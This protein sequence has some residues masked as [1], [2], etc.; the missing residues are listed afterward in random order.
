MTVALVAMSHSPLLG[1]GSP[2]PADIDRELTETFDTA[3]AFVREFD[4]TLVISFAPDHYNGFFHELMPPFCVGFAAESTGD[5]DSPTGPL[6]VPG[7]L[8]ASLAQSVLDADVDVAI[9]RRMIVD[10]GAVQPLEIL[11]GGIDAIPVIPVFVNGL[12][13]PFAPMRRVRRLGEAIGRF[14]AG[15]DERVL[16]IGSGGLSHDPPVP[17]WATATDVQRRLLLD[18]KNPTPQARAAREQRVKDAAAE[19]VVG[20]STMRDLNPEWDNRFL[21][22]CAAG[23]PQRFD[24]YHHAEMT[25]A[26]GSSAHEVRSWVAAFSAL[27]ASGDYQVSTRYYRPIRELIAGFGLLTAA[28]TPTGH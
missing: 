8:A 25:A 22:T 3:R 1:A 11:F 6:D 26:A 27:A 21:D 24:D 23:D 16:L 13:Q 10:H 15:L 19:F 7:D 12:A 9:S 4:P 5:Y 18:G 14:A 17:Q 28:P 2:L 20:H